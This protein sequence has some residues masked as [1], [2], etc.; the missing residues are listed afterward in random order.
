MLK[1]CSRWVYDFS[2]TDTFL[3]DTDEGD[4][5]AEEPSNTWMFETASQ[6]SQV[7][8]I[9]M[10]VDEV[11]GYSNETSNESENTIKK[12]GDCK[13][14]MEK[15]EKDRKVLEK[16]EDTADVFGEVSKEEMI[17]EEMKGN[18]GKQELPKDDA[19]EIKVQEGKKALAKTKALAKQK[20]LAKTKPKALAKTKPKALAKQ[21]AL[22]KPKPKAL[23]KQKALAQAKKSAL[24]KKKDQA[25]KA[26]QAKKKA[27]KE[28][29][30][31]NAEGKTSQDAAKK[32]G[33]N[34]KAWV[35]IFLVKFK[36]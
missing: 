25:K 36:I 17:E 26:A 29:R 1:I 23:A 2:F 6:V 18:D 9:E 31:T 5:C 14:T 13:E 15:N 11:G 16:S 35:C 24:Q 33:S 32:K 34:E 30:Q 3:E 8:E 22:A 27:K 21:K 12:V 7:E 10:P 20:A 28:Q 19:R 4:D